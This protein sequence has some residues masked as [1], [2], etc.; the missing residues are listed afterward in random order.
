MPQP[1]LDSPQEEKDEQELGVQ[2]M[3]VVYSRACLTAG[4][5]SATRITSQEQ[6][7]AI[8]TM[9]SWEVANGGK[10]VRAGNRNTPCIDEQAMYLVLEL[11]KT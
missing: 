9:L 11:L 6:M 10:E 7:N 8:Q 4:L 5:L 3:D 1:G 2:A